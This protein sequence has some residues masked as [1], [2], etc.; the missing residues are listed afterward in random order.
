MFWW[1]PHCYSSTLIFFNL[2]YKYNC[3]HEIDVKKQKDDSFCA[4][5]LFSLDLIF[6]LLF[7]LLFFKLYIFGEYYK[8]SN[9][10][11]HFLAKVFPRVEKPRG[12][13]QVSDRK[14][15]QSVKAIKKLDNQSKNRCWLSLQARVQISDLQNLVKPV[16]RQWIEIKWY[17]WHHR[18]G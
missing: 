13:H 3:S 7:V 1:V 10:E 2:S 17:H 12:R 11:C 14:I 9:Q 15:I 5:A 16:L 4:T 6:S 18:K 8:R